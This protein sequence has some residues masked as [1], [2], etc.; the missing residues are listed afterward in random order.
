MR[1]IRASYAILERPPEVFEISCAS[2]TPVE[3][4]GQVPRFLSR[5]Y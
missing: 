4:K 2:A 5:R 1:Y 3:G